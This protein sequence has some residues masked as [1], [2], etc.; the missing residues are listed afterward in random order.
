MANWTLRKA[1]PGDTAALAVC[2][3]AA[4]A[5]YATRIAD[6]PPVSEGIA[7]E[8]AEHQVW[9]AEID[10]AVVGGLVLM[11]EHGYMR[12]A[13]V[14]VHPDHKGIGLGHAFM[15]LAETEASAQGYRE[16]RLTTHADMLENVA[17]YI[18]LGWQEAG[19]DGNRMFM[20]K[21]V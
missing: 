4:Y 19:R 3:D 8:I 15:T 10:G 9:V 12:L 6:L 14:A 16:M 18:H 11:A 13:N 2:I 1:K 20:T 5:E 21:A 17:L 7:E